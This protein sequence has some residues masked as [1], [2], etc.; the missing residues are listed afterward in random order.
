M[1]KTIAAS[2]FFDWPSPVGEHQPTHD[3]GNQ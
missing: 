1:P 2:I 3:D